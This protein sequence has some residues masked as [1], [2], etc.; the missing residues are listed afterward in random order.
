MSE[1]EELKLFTNSRGR[2]QYDDMADLYAILKTTE[3]LEIAYSRD[4]VGQKEY[5]AACQR[6]ISQFRT[7]ESALVAAGTIEDVGSFCQMYQVE[8]PRAVDRL[9]R[10]GVPA[11]VMHNM[12]DDRQDAAKVAETVQ[13]FITAMDSVKLGQNA[14][15]DVQP[16]ISDLTASLTRVSG[17]TQDF[18]GVVKLQEW[19]VTLNSLRAVDELGEEQVRQLSLDLD[20]AYSAFHRF[21][22]ASGEAK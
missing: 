10:V 4:S 3:H 11:T 22:Q 21:L 12:T 17:I 18:E 20:S 15:D 1:S 13:H 2:R 9:L 6:L 19:L 7:T 8:C 5:E 14:V 16:L